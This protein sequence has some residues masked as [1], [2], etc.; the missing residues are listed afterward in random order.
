MKKPRDIVYGVDDIPPLGVT[1]LSGLQ[2]A[3]L[4]SISVVLPLTVAREAGLSTAVQA[5]VV[6]LSM[7]VLGVGTVLQALRAGPVG[8][9]FLC[10]SLF[11]A[12]YISASVAAARAGGF[13][14]VLGMTLL[15]GGL[16]AVLARLQRHLRPLFPPEIAGFVVALL[17]LTLGTLGL[18][19]L[20]GLDRP[21]PVAPAELAVA[22]ASLG[23]MVGLNVWGGRRLRLF[24][25]L[26]GMAV[27][28]AA[29][30]PAGLLGW[31]AVERVLSAPLFALPSLGHLAWTFDPALLL[32]F[33]IAALAACFKAVGTITTCQR[34]NDADWVRPELASIQRGVLAD[35]VGTATAGLAG[36]VG[37]N[38]S[39]SA[40]GVAAAT[41]ITSRQV[42]WAIGGIFVVLAVLPRTAA[43]LAVMPRPV[44]A[45]ALL[46][47]ACFVLVSGLQIITSR[48][49][50]TR[51]TFV[52]GLGFLAALA[53]EVFPGFFQS[54]PPRVQP[55]V[56]SSLV[57]GL[58]TAVG[59]NLAFRLGVR[60][61][62]AL[63]VAPQDVD[64]AQIE[65]FMESHGGAW[66]ARR[67]VIERASFNLTQSI[68]TIVEACAPASALEVEASFDEFN[69]DVRVSW[70][71][72]PLELPERRP[73]NEE[74]MDS[75]DG[76]RRLAGFLL[77]RQADRVQSS[78]RQ[79]R[80]TVL[81][82][83]DH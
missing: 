50:D 17:G 30:V 43:A 49:L 7:L 58:L 13:P 8:S 62:V 27:G 54:L 15:A 42:A 72:P 10:P 44:V 34:I 69:L 55:F 82:H 33:A 75:E 81:F 2:Q 79:G 41:G 66:G 22:L 21:P 35:A 12:A 9:G 11:S 39:P 70:A 68:E 64:P 36:T 37:V 51:R 26:G 56:A 60:R 73:T 38:T 16:E 76:H 24:C 23:T 25:V 46:F 20:L 67:D 6:G 47:S 65:D 3:A 61:R 77:R 74:I 19:S 40:V 80:S 53:V 59:L 14:L 28:Y 71:G 52:I 5:D 4:L 31:P 1:L 45:A 63:L 48:L 18:R 29:A 78:H 32:P 57:P 83:F